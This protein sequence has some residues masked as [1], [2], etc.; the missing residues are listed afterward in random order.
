M[1]FQYV[2]LGK[3][4]V[5]SPVE[6]GALNAFIACT[7]QSCLVQGHIIVA[8]AALQQSF[9]EDVMLPL[10]TLQDFWL[11]ETAF[12]AGDE[13]SLAD[14]QYACE[15]QQLCLLDGAEQ[16]SSSLY[17]QVHTYTC[18]HSSTCLCTA[19]TSIHTR[20]L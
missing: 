15:I 18:L 4:F 8:S 12:V 2:D 3:G 20:A 10:Q 1:A 9:S 17:M 16:V 7:L 13:I 11:A 14:L 5:A 19:S 6:Q